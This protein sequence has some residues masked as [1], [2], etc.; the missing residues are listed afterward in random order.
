VSKL[1]KLLRTVLLPKILLV[2]AAEAKTIVEPIIAILPN[3]D[4]IFLIIFLYLLSSFLIN[5]LIFLSKIIDLVSIR[6]L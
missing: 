6:P 5:N 3:T 2:E 4:I 1:P